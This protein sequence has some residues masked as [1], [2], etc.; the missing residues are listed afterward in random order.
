MVRKLCVV[1]V[2]LMIV[3]FVT[4]PL[5][6]QQSKAVQGMA[7]ILLTMNHFPSDAEKATLKQLADDKATTAQERVLLQALAGIQHTLGAGD[8]AKVEA[9]VKDP[10]ASDGVKT[11]AGILAKFNHM[12]TDA[13]KAAL[14]KLVS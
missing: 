11:I 1:A 2:L 12:A 14:K 8:K 10:A 4:S 6:A 3:S 9:L 13:D 7:K 5:A